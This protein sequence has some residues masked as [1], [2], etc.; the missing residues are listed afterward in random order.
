MEWRNCPRKLPASSNQIIRLARTKGIFRFLFFWKFRIFLCLQQAVSRLGRFDFERQLQ[1]QKR[2]R[3]FHGH[4]GPPGSEWM[5]TGLREKF[6]TC[7][8]HSFFPRFTSACIR[9]NRFR[10]GCCSEFEKPEHPHPPFHL[11]SQSL[12]GWWFGVAEK[13]L[14][15]LAPRVLVSDLFGI[16]GKK[17]NQRKSKEFGSHIW[18]VNFLG[19]FL[20]SISPRFTRFTYPSNRFLKHMPQ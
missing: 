9:G 12:S 4:G 3:R 2:T 14:S 17:R 18:Q 16:K 7:T 5:A 11:S 10:G 19:S 8:C 6:W 13:F 1:E 20:F 15:S